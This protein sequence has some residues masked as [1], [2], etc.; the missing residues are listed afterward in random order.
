MAYTVAAKFEDGAFSI[1]L[2]KALLA[3][4]TRLIPNKIVSM[5]VDALVLEKH[6]ST[7][8]SRNL[9][10]KYSNPSLLESLWDWN[11]CTTQGVASI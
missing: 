6:D 3:L 11:L 9:S 10:T 8:I 2:E 4:E 1:N 5:I 7:E